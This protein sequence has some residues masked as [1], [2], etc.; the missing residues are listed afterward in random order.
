MYI[1]SVV[2]AHTK[3][4]KCRVSMMPSTVAGGGLSGGSL[5]F[6][7]GFSKSVEKSRKVSKS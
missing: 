5:H 7:D 4:T 6:F 3:S 1:D 2:G